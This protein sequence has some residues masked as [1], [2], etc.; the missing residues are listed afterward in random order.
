[1]GV[2]DVRAGNTAE[3][4]RR[5]AGTSMMAVPTDAAADSLMRRSVMDNAG[6]WLWRAIRS[7]A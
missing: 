4:A 7:G 2:R 5:R 6:L 3:A 1:M